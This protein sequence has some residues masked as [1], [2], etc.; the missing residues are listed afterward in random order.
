MERQAGCVFRPMSSITPDLRREWVLQ[1]RLHTHPDHLHRNH[2]DQSIS[3]YSQITIHY[4]CVFHTKKVNSD[5]GCQP[6]YLLLLCFTEESTSYGF[7]TTCG[8]VH[9]DRF[10][11]KY[12]FKHT[13]CKTVMVLR[14]WFCLNTLSGKSFIEVGKQSDLL[15]FIWLCPP[16]HWLLTPVQ[17]AEGILRTLFSNAKFTLQ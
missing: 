8:W 3:V 1:R 14:P 7:R 16:V 13:N 11:V 4:Q 9:D 12:S 2:R 15:A 6:A 17:Q 5:W 10:R